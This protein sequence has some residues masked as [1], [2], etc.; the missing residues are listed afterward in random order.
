MRLGAGYRPGASLRIDDR[1]PR[2]SGRLLPNIL[3]CYLMSSWSLVRLFT[4]AA[5]TKADGYDAPLVDRFSWLTLGLMRPSAPFSVARCT[6][7]S[8][9][10][11]LALVRN[12]E[13]SERESETCDPGRRPWP[14]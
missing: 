3:L 2:N 14:R 13:R 1:S 9:R 10:D 8:E 11:N 6:R 4:H 7:G 5:E 12:V